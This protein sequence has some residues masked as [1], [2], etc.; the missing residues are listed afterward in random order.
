[1]FKRKAEKKLEDWL[2]KDDALLA[3]GARQV[4]KSFLIREF[5]KAHFKSFVEINLYEKPEWIPVLE[6]ARN[7]DDLLFR[8]SA[9]GE[10]KLMEGDTLIFFDEIQHARKADLITLS[11][12]LV[13][14]GR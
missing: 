14:K 12:F 2:Q 13:E 9:L 4:G 5:G 7:A 8:I 6:N 11:K 1:M 3:L 10:G